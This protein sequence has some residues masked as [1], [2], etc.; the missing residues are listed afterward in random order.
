MYQ[1]QMMPA[2]CMLLVQKVS[3]DVALL[4]SICHTFVAPGTGAKTHDVVCVQ[5]QMYI[6]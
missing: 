1:A 4:L 5:P 6:K 3:S 2:V